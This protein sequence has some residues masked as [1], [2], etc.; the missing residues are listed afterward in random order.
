MSFVQSLSLQWSKSILSNRLYLSFSQHVGILEC[1]DGATNLNTVT[2]VM[3][4]LVFSEGNPVWLNIDEDD[5]SVLPSNIIANCLFE[6]VRLIFIRVLTR[7]NLSQAE[8]LVISVAMQW[9]EIHQVELKNDEYSLKIY[10]LMKKIFSE[11]TVINTN[12][13]SRNSNMIT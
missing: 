2:N 1:F 8:H 4:A 12:Y 5:E 13:R 9:C 10:H 3:S 7:G 11:Y 6:S